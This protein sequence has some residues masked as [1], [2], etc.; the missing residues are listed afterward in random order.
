MTTFH[1]GQQDE[2][3]GTMSR[4]DLIKATRQL[5]CSVVILSA[6]ADGKQGTMTASAMYVSEKPPLI[7]VSISKT[8]HTYQLIDRS[9]EFAINVV[10]EQQLE[11]AKKVGSS[12]GKDVDKFHEFNIVTE[13]AAEI[14]A[15][16]IANSFATFECRVRMSLWDVEGNHAIYIAEVVAFKVNEK[17]EPL[18]WFNN[19]YFKVGTACRM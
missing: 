4:N 19:G 6:A 7:A 12:H 9:K 16:L 17:L 2:K 8:F 18:V 13:P 1:L 14:K 11:L 3:E 10:T 5:P 15:P